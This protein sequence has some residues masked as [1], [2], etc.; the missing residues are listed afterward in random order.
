MQMSEVIRVVLSE[1]DKLCFKQFCA[2]RGQTM[3]E[4][5]RQCIFTDIKKTSRDEENLRQLHSIW[6]TADEKIAASGLSIPSDAEIDEYIAECR[7]ER[8]AKAL[9]G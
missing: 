9:V 5:L 7:R 4:R 1:E 2:D 8:N 3:S 6:K